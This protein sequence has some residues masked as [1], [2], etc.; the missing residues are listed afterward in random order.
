MHP[1][2]P[3]VAL[4]A[5]SSTSDVAGTYRTGVFGSTAWIWMYVARNLEGLLFAFLDLWQEWG[6]PN[7][8]IFSQ[9]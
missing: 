4:V 2:R 6:E 7:F 5:Y 3:Y 1:S 9:N 8:Q